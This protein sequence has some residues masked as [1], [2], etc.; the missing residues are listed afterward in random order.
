MQISFAFS[1]MYDDVRYDGEAYSK[2]ACLVHFCTAC[3]HND[4]IAV[5]LLRQIY[6]LK[7]LTCQQN[8]IHQ[9]NFV[10]TYQ[11]IQL[12]QSGIQLELKEMQT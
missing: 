12:L 6:G 7:G 2:L 1:H 4:R 3:T 8:P 9:M 5:H 11:A 10:Y